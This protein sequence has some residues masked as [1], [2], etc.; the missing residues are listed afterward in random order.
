M[1]FDSFG[2]I[3]NYLRIS[4]T[5][6]CN[7]RCVYC[8]PEGKNIV[9]SKNKMMS[10]DEIDKLAS[11][12]INMG[13]N[14][15][16]ITG[17]EP[18]V[19]KDIKEIL[20]ILS[21]YPVELTVTTNAYLVNSF[22]DVFNATGIK[23]LNVSLDTF[24][25]EQ[26]SVLTKR[27]HFNKIFSNICLLLENNF[28]VKVNFVVMKDVNENSI[29]D[30]IEWTKDFPLEVR[31][32]EFMPFNKNNWSEEKVFSYKDILNLINTKYHFEKIE[33]RIHD[34]SRKFKARGHLGTFGIISTI[35]KPFCNECNRLRLTS[36]GKLKNCLFSKEEIDLLTPLRNGEDVIP[37]IHSSLLNKKEER[38]GQ[39]NSE[40]IINR[41]MV[42]IG[43]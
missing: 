12:F 20:S 6:A 14:K 42:S 17:G 36:D 18:L 8:M 30:F 4:V 13:I 16:R 41:S 25:P 26:F 9:T 7:L 27:N 11:V 43:G 31:F 39:F 1:L 24:S 15:I 29:L 33:D 22:I 19:R 28:N 21:E 34:T 23:N 37:I 10:A 38:G 32:I 40:E 3:H 2:R 35:T 5:D